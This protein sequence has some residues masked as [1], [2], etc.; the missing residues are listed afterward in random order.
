MRGDLVQSGENDRDREEHSGASAEVPQEVVTM[1]LSTLFDEL[2]IE[3]SIFLVKGLLINSWRNLIRF[4][5]ADTSMCLTTTHWFVSREIKEELGRKWK[6]VSKTIE[7]IA[8]EDH[9][10]LRHIGIVNIKSLEQ[11]RL[12]IDVP[13]N[14]DI[15]KTGD[16]CLRT[17]RFKLKC[18]AQ[19][20][21]PS[22]GRK[23]HVELSTIPNGQAEPPIQHDYRFA[24]ST[25]R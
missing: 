21:K 9:K 18:Y 12:E 22:G 1:L 17:E 20:S 7:V 3:T 24:E 6:D 14:S 15:S 19:G 23:H 16:T 25:V 2:G 10:S 5:R 8:P 13:M 11:E 4:E